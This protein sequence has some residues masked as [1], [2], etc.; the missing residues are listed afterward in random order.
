MD[1]VLVLIAAPGS[2]A[3]DGPSIATLRGLLGSEPRWLGEGEALEFDLQADKG[4][5]TEDSVRRLLESRPVDIAVLPRRNRRK[6]L[7][8][9][10]MDSTIIEQEC[11]DELADFAGVG[12]QIKAITERAMRGDIDFIP[13]L[14]ERV[15]LLKGVSRTMIDRVIS[16]RMTFRP[17]GK[18]LVKTMSACGALTALVSGGFSH[19]T[20]H[21]ANEVGFAFNQANELLFEGEVLVGKVKE[22]ALG[23]DAK[24][25]ALCALAS[26]LGLSPADTIA[27]GD[28]A[29]DV[30]MLEASG[31]GVAF[32]AKPKVR[33]AAHAVIDHGDL[34]ALLYLQGYRREEFK[35]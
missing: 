11:I 24:L 29:N 7:L 32:H 15:A 13:A 18:T 8:V 5:E 17:G 14:R 20:A 19:F 3:L 1:E 4:A 6:K 2:E 25:E 21:V 22:P 10:D 33:E 27:V 35:T 31:L 12:P 23:R 9:A 26:R 30:P 16:E 34:T 28:G